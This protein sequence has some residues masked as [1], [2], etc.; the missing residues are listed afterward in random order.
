MFLHNLFTLTLLTRYNDD[1]NIN[2][3][4]IYCYYNFFYNKETKFN[5]N[6]KQYFT[7]LI[8]LITCI[9][10]KYDTYLLEQYYIDND[11]DLCGLKTITSGLNW[12]NLDNVS[13]NEI[14]T[15]I[16]TSEDYINK[17]ISEIVKQH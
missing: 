15:I 7:Y 4:I 12:F 9:K 13:K 6:V 5:I 17:Q 11:L 3:L 16:T 14:H 2:K 1:I 8:S 10:K